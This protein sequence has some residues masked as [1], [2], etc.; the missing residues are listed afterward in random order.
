ME[1]RGPRPQLLGLQHPQLCGEPIAHRS[2]RRYAI[3]G[4]LNQNNLIVHLLDKLTTSAFDYSANTLC[5]YHEDLDNRYCARGLARALCYMMSQMLCPVFD[6]TPT[7]NHLPPKREGVVAETYTGHLA[8]A[9]PFLPRYHLSHTDEEW[10][11]QDS[12]QQRETPESAKG[13]VTGIGRGRMGW[14]GR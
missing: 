9:K 10:Q 14:D 11:P 7:E 6:I 4:P 3:T 8:E 2:H 1:C 5:E 12:H 13:R